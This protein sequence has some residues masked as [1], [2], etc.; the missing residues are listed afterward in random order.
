MTQT[1]YNEMA[2]L[3]TKISPIINNAILHLLQILCTDPGGLA[4]IVLACL[5]L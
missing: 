5:V 4:F 1:N 2:L 3:P